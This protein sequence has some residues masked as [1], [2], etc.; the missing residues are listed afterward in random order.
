MREEIW[1]LLFSSCGTTRLFC[2][3]FLSCLH[4][5]GVGSGLAELGLSQ[6][7]GDSWEETLAPERL[8]DTPGKWRA[9]SLNHWWIT[10]SP[11]QTLS[12]SDCACR[13]GLLSG[14]WVNVLIRCIFT[15]VKVRVLL[16]RV[17]WQ[18]ELWRK[19]DR[20]A[21]CGHSTGQPEH[22]D[23]DTDFTGLRTFSGIELPC[24]NRWQSI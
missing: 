20:V 21:A 18:E 4:R 12:T 11:G 17:F 16:G 15:A 19:T 6:S 2:L 7:H 5:L 8:H 22:W 9:T 23:H 1:S 10:K 24:D 14:Y 3:C 13:E